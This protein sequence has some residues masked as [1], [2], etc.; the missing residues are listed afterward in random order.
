MPRR[1][2]PSRPV[3]V[4]L[5]Q[6]HDTT[7]IEAAA[8]IIGRT[9]LRREGSFRVVRLVSPA[10]PRLIRRTSSQRVYPVSDRGRQIDAFEP[11][12]LAAMVDK[13]SRMAL[14]A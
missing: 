3:R 11:I 14:R 10:L 12:S 9:S 2:E 1:A 13:A 5:E 8:A 6:R 4:T 7:A